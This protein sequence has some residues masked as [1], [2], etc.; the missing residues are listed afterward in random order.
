M[1][2]SVC[3][4]MC[5]YFGLFAIDRM[6]SAN[7]IPSTVQPAQVASSGQ[8][9]PLVEQIARAADVHE[10]MA[11]ARPFAGDVPRKRALIPALW[12][13]WAAADESTRLMLV[14]GLA[15]LRSSKGMM[16]WK[17]EVT[18]NP[19]PAVRQDLLS[20]LP[21]DGAFFRAVAETSARR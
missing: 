12:K 9:D 16:L 21:D 7:R 1:F 4:L 20:D 13:R 19:D 14:V 17:K 15:S 11:L 10:A 3:A 2:R 18:S 8:V 6:E 5:A